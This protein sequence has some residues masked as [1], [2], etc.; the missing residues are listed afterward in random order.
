MIFYK[1]TFISGLSMATASYSSRAEWLQ[2]EPQRT[3]SKLLCG[4]LQER[5]HRAWLSVWIRVERKGES[6]SHSVVSYS[7]Q[8]RG[9]YSLRN[10][11]SHSFG[12]GSLS[13]LQGIFQ[14]QGLNSE[15][16]TLQGDSLPAE[17]PGKPKN[18]GVGSLFILQRIFL[19]W[20]IIGLS[21]IAW[22]PC[23]CTKG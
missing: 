1:N 16:P 3:E 17:P 10:S 5:L 9:L 2:R 12:V 11:P 18:T 14:T 21:C 13:L 22:L 6:E 15:S 7:L 20:N 4:T 8:P 23:F 19:T